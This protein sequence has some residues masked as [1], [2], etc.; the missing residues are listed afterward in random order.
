M[1]AGPRKHV[2]VVAGAVSLYDMY[3]AA[4]FKNSASTTY[5]RHC[6]DDAAFKARFDNQK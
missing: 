3:E 5:S 1:T 6:Q 2:H 4:G